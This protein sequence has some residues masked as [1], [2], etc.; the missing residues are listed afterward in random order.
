M[1]NSKGVKYDGKTSLGDFSNY[2]TFGS[3]FKEAHAAGGSGHTF[4]Y[5]DKLY[6]TN[7]KDGGD[8]RKSKDDRD[9]QN[10]L[11]RAKAHDINALVKD[12]TGVYILD[13]FFGNFQGNW[14]SELDK[15]RSNYHHFEALK[16]SKKEKKSSDLYPDPWNDDSD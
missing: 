16:Q 10:H 2:K 15:Q 6:N 12:Y 11:D 14:S 4:T 8:Y 9:A 1:G 13:E 5:K 3:A 7:C